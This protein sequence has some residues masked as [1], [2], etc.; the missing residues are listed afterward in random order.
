M[1]YGKATEVII[2]KVVIMKTYVMDTGIG[3]GWLI[4]SSNLGGSGLSPDQGLQQKC[5]NK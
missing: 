5:Q 4:M 3:C 2:K 1:K